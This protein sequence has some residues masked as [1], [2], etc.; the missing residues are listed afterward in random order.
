[1]Q[2]LYCDT[3]VENFPPTSLGGASPQRFD[4]LNPNLADEVVYLIDVPRNLQDDIVAFLAD[5]GITSIAFS[6]ATEYLDFGRRDTAACVILNISLPDLSGL[7]LQRQLAETANPPVIFISDRCDIASTVRAMKAG[8][9]EFL[10][11]PPDLSALVAAVKSAFTQDRRQ[12]QQKAELVKL[13]ERFS[14][15]TPRE[16]DVLPLIVGGLLNKQAASVLGISE[17]TLQ[18]HRSQIMRKMRAE[19]FADLVRMAIR[20][21]VRYWRG[22]LPD[23]G[24]R[25]RLDMAPE[26]QRR[27]KKADRSAASVLLPH[28]FRTP[29]DQ[30][31]ETNGNHLGDFLPPETH[32]AAT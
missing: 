19:S 26:L 28:C 20:L 8:A 30:Q 23:K 16:R 5:I 11:T 18:I 32:Y 10:T 3:S 1:M 15:L 6:A 13:Q 17:V 4:S 2:T 9:I 25:A 7:K 31:R 22:T 27:S 21:R 24:V 29:N 14:F 12:R